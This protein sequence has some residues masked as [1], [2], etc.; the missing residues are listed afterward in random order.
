[1]VRRGVGQPDPWLYET[2]GLVAIGVAQSERILRR[3]GELCHVFEPM[4][5]QQ[6]RPQGLS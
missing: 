4:L 1:M 2:S 5:P 6:Y 3:N